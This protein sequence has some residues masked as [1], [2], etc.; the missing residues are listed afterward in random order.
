MAL[1]TKADWTCEKN[2]C[3]NPLD[4]TSPKKDITCQVKLI[5]A[6]WIIAQHMMHSLSL[7]MR[8]TDQSHIAK[9]EV[10][11]SHA[12]H[13]Y[14]HKISSRNPSYKINGTTLKTLQRMGINTIQ[15]LGNWIIDEHGTITLQ[16]RQLTFDKHWTQAAR[17]N[18]K[19]VTTLLRDHLQL[20]DM[21]TGPLDLAIPRQIRQTKAENQI[22]N[23]VNI[24]GFPPSRAT[25]GTTW[26]SDGSMTPA[27]ATMM[28]E[29]TIT[30]AATGTKTLVMR[31]PGRN[32]SILHGEQL[33]LI[34]ALILSQAPTTSRPDSSPEPNRLLTDHLNS[35]RL[36]EDSQTEVSQTPRLRYMNGRSYYRWILSLVERS[37]LR[38]CYTPGHSTDNTLETRMN[39]EADHL[40]S[41]SQKIFRILPEAPPPTFHMND[42]TLH[43]KTDGW[44]ES[45]VPHYVDALMIRQ[46]QMAL[47]YGHGQR[48]STWAHDKTPPPDYPYLKATSAHSAAV[49]LYARSGQL[50]TADTLRQR[51]KIDDDTCRLGCDDTESARHLF[52][53]CQHYQQWR[54]E[55]SKQI[56][57]KT[58]L[59][60]ETIGC[61][62]TTTD[63]LIS[64]AKSL[65]IDDHKIWP[66]HYSLYYLGQIPCLKQLIADP[67]INFIQRRRLESHI[68][69]DWHLSSIR[70]AGRIFGDFQKR[71]AA[72][73][74][75]PKRKF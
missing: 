36:I 56:V 60:I 70:L 57:E 25:N 31:I 21:V 5:P 55:A 50:A 29:K 34:I 46:T 39:N 22:Q 16:S 40:A 42:F 20:D 18:W 43:H 12:V 3:I 75:C 72:L 41:S 13:I 69:T 15:D 9:G 53:K 68:A 47:G 7:S 30:G 62:E 35:V 32:V 65:F 49:Q 67:D 33:G 51:K 38:I 73:N 26:A 63:N 71:M 37:P 10:S 19:T 64:A 4:G 58:K 61:G 74:Q 14:N 2:G 27:S 48:M 54:D 28:D 44:I 66:L 8:E 17:K 52:I 11:L 24:C 6:N 1:I 59:K 45:N 23:L